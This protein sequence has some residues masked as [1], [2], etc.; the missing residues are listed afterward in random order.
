MKKLIVPVVLLSIFSST[1]F[2]EEP[3]TKQAEHEE[4]CLVTPPVIK[5]VYVNVPGPTVY[6]DKA[7]PG[8]TVY[9]NVPGPTVYVDKPIVQ[10][11]TVVE[12]Q[13]V[14]VP[15]PVTQVQVQVENPVNIALQ[16]KFDGLKSKYASLLKSYKSIHNHEVKE[17]IKYLSRKHK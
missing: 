10:T 3:T 11:Q 17:K 9:V 14:S 4:G 16:A 2:A 1:A 6:V 15:G 7:V 12:T 5:T 8:P 13:T